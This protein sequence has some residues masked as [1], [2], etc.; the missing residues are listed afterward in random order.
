MDVIEGRN[1]HKTEPEV[2]GKDFISLGKLLRKVSTVKTFRL[3]T[4]KIKQILHPTLS[5]HLPSNYK[6]GMMRGAHALGFKIGEC[7]HIVWK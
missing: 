5:N 3:L 1:A 7:R 4:T 2:K 6:L